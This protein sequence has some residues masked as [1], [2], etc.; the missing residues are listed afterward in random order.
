VLPLQF[1]TAPLA[2]ASMSRRARSPRAYPAAKCSAVLAL[3][4]CAHASCFSVLCQTQ[5]AVQDSPEV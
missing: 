3:L 4:S 2:P 5:P 1:S